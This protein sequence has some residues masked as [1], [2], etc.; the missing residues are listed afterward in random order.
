MA[1]QFI[2]SII[3]KE[4]ENTIV[5]KDYATTSYDNAKSHFNKICILYMTDDSVIYE[6]DDGWSMW[7]DSDDCKYIV[8]LETY[9]S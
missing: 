4:D 5:E 2:V 6:G 8:N 1:R 7:C 9:N 3:L